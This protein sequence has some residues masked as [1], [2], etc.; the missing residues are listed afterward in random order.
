M[1]MD[2][3]VHGTQDAGTEDAGTNEGTPMD[4]E[5]VAKLPRV[6][7]VAAM[8]TGAVVVMYVA[9]LPGNGLFLVAAGVA[10]F[11][12]A[13]I[14][15]C[16]IGFAVLLGSIAVACGMAALVT[17]YA[18]FLWLAIA[19]LVVPAIVGW[20]AGYV[21]RHVAEAGPRAALKDARVW[22]AALGVVATVAFIV[23]IAGEL[24]A[25]PP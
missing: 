9:G 2:V 18:T 4:R 19:S 8:G 15:P 25:N 7:V 1:D 13:I 10:G 16:W 17:G 5:L 12:T 11:V 20:L 24:G 22:V 14:A 3:A 6:I 21:A 23:W